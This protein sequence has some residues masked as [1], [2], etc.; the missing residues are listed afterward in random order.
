MNG[1]LAVIGLGPG[2]LGLLTAEAR[3][4]VEQADA[5]FGYGPYVDRLPVRDGQAR[6][7]SDNRAE[8]SRAQAALMAAEAG[9]CVAVVSGGDPGIF[10]M[11]AAV[12][13]A[14]EH[15]PDSW[16]DIAVTVHPGITAML[17]LAARIG[18]PLGHDFCAISLSDLLT[19]LP[20]IERRLQAAIDG[21]F[22]IA[23]YNPASLKRR[24]PLDMAVALLRA[25][26]PAA[27][28]VVIARNLGRADE[29]VR[30]VTLGAL[31]PTEI[32]MLTILIVGSS[33]TRC[34]PSG[35]FTPRG[36]AQK[37]RSEASS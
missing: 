32:D 3:A 34:G 4:A 26:R 7:V 36:Y 15:G 17:A 18:A 1:R 13:E 5:L 6:H 29:L 2:P 21:D 23:L 19:P 22:V 31:D 11:A 27:T 16:R 28:P 33:A 35:V 25:G 14:V 20:A 9:A 24:A 37:P 30:V 12:C 10:A 8:L